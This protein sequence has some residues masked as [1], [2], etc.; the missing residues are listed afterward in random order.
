MS[1]SLLSVLALVTA[2][3]S[4]LIG[5][6]F[7]AFSN[8]VMPAL[9]RLPAGQ[10]MAAMQS[11][12][13]TVLNRWFLGVFLGTAAG[14]VLLAASSLWTWDLGAQLRLGGGVLYLAGTLLVTRACNIPLNDALAKLQPAA[15][16][17]AAFWTRYVTDWT[18]WNHVRTLA[19]LLA[20]A[21]LTVSLFVK[22]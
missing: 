14:C 21:L 22:G 19:A 15:V 1:A 12:N 16:D 2:L 3:G 13:V 5:G 20:A 4:G 11:I 6:V 9:S 18:V 10:G 7:F 17:A 8:F